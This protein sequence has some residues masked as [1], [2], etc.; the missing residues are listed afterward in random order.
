M[1][2]TKDNK[3]VELQQ[4]LA[5]IFV[6]GGVTVTSVTQIHHVATVFSKEYKKRTLEEGRISTSDKAFKRVGNIYKDYFDI[7]Q[8][9]VAP[10]VGNKILTEFFLDEIPDD[11]RQMLQDACETKCNDKRT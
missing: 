6:Y 11:T 7:T 5:A 4:V 10:L 3:A 9:A 2:N 1:K 8:D